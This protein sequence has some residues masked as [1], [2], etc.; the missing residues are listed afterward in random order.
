MKDSYL[1]R[2][3][4]REYGT[5]QYVDN[6]IYKSQTPILDANLKRDI[7]VESKITNDQKVLTVWSSNYIVPL[8]EL[9]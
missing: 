4:L 3:S 8:K 1:K 5:N 6:L 2:K 7:S 9:K